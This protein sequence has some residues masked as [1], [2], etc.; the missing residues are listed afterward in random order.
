MTAETVGMCRCGHLKSEHG[1]KALER[2]SSAKIKFVP[3]AK[4]ATGA[5]ASYQVDVTAEKFGTC[6][7]GFHK[8]AH[9]ATAAGPTKAEGKA[10]FVEAKKEATGAC[11][12][13]K[14][15][16]H[17]VSSGQCVCGLPKTAHA[18]YDGDGPV[19][20]AI[21]AEEAIRAEKAKKK[22]IQRR[23]SEIANASE[24]VCVPNSFCAVC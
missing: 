7:C 17:A 13:Y 16:L 8:T 4:E 6:K 5:C 15:D 11:S 20:K 21:R 22:E 9:T 3:I 10:V 24:P 2:Q 12:N 23:E 1:A 14:V 18:H 19:L